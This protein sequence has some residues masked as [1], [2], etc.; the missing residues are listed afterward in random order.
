MR[1]TVSRL[2]SALIVLALCRSVAAGELARGRLSGRN[3]AVLDRLIAETGRRGPGDDRRHRPYVVCDWDNTS[4]FGDAE[5]T[6][7]Y[8][9]VDNLA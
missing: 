6:L 5:E 3:Q 8:F 1:R 2:V 4:A 7:T 9:L